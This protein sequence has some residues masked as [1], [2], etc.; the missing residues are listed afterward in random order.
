MRK[1][2]VGQSVKRILGAAFLGL[3]LSSCGFNPFCSVERYSYHE[4]VPVYLQPGEKSKIES[5]APR[6]IGETGKI[7]LHHNLIF[8]N[9]PEKGV[10]IFDNTD[11][12]TP[13]PLSFVAVPGNHD[14]LV[15]EDVGGT[16]LYA[17][18][19]NDLVVLDIGNPREIS[20][21]KQLKDVFSAFYPQYDAEP[22]KGFLVGYEEGDL[23]T[24]SYRRC[25]GVV[26]DAP[27][28]Q[29]GTPN[30]PS[31]GGDAGGASQGGSLARFALLG[32]YLYTIDSDAIQ[33]FRLET[34]ADP[35]LFNRTNVAFGIETLFPYTEGANSQLYVGGN[36]GL[37]IMDASDPGNLRK[38]GEVSHVQSCDP[39]VVQGDLAYVTLR[40]ECFGESNRLEII[41]VSNPGTPELVT[42]YTL[43]EPYGLGVDG[44]YLFVCDGV[45]GLKV[46]E[47]ARSPKNLELIKQLSGVK[48]RDIIPFGGVALVVAEN[49]LFQ[50]DYS[51]LAAGEMTLLSSISVEK[52]DDNPKD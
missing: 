3:F 34:P 11:P 12:R 31:T 39:V 18:N 6:S 5:S 7:Y 16:L 43:Q 29:P 24:E 27:P 21:R 26:Y 9:E 49:G 4:L 48:A 40:G 20:V 14:L 38:Q 8:V 13:V 1:M 32:D 52:T 45:A 37:Y 50:Y 42:D 15:R 35:V 36:Q 33:S 28:P 47:N 46:Y 19:Y 23:I 25:S 2:V 44:D 41:D 22:G 30:S 51:R 17:D 10:H